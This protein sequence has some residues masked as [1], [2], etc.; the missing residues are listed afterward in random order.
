MLILS[1]PYSCMLAVYIHVFS[2]LSRCLCLCL[3]LY[4][5]RRRRFRRTAWGEDGPPKMLST[6]PMHPSPNISR[7]TAIGCE[8]KYELTRSQR[9]NLFCSEIEVVGQEK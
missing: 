4:H 9:R 1:M 2:P 7:S 3:T 8:A 6:R 5:G